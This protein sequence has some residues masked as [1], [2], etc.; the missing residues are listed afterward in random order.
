MKK[1]FK[2]KLNLNKEKISRFES[3]RI[4]GGAVTDGVNTVCG[5]SLDCGTASAELVC[6]DPNFTRDGASACKCK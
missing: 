1:E 2:G 6:G 5:C 4:K 3:A